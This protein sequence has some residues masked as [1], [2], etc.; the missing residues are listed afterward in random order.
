MNVVK[1]GYM[2]RRKVDLFEIVSY[3]GV[4]YKY[5]YYVKCCCIKLLSY[6]WFLLKRRR[7]MLCEMLLSFDD[8]Y[9]F[10]VEMFVDKVSVLFVLLKVN[11]FKCNFLVDFGV[12]ENILSL[13]VLKVCNVKLKFCDIRVYV[14]NFSDLFYVL[15]KFFVLVEFKWSV[16]NFGFLFCIVNVVLVEK[17]IFIR[18]F[19]LFVGFGKMNNV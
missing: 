7:F 2:I 19:S 3:G 13:S 16:V 9:G 15:G 17:N 6:S 10:R 1:V 11:G 4:C 18:Y 14:Y 8:G 5:G 12:S